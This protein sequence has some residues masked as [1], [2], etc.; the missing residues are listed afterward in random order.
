MEILVLKVSTNAFLP[1]GRYQRDKCQT[2]LVSSVAR[3][4]G[5]PQPCLEILSTFSFTSRRK[6]SP[7]ATVPSKLSSRLSS[8]IVSFWVGYCSFSA[9]QQYETGC[10]I[11]VSS[12]EFVKV[13][14]YIDKRLQP[15]SRW[16]KYSHWPSLGLTL[17]TDLQMNWQE[18]PPRALEPSRQPRIPR[19]PLSVP[20]TPTPSLGRQLPISGKSNVSLSQTQ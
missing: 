12:I 13:W 5:A 6:G 1:R 17:G 10:D 14:S 20:T 15:R 3:K 19:A 4:S 16:R 9:W 2:H 8:P 11:I 18:L 7:Y